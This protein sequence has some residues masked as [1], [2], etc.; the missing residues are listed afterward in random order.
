MD[1][2]VLA[3]FHLQEDYDCQ[4]VAWQPDEA[5]DDTALVDQLQLVVCLTLLLGRGART[6]PQSDHE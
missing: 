1:H 2:H 6:D 3:G 5:V 4:L